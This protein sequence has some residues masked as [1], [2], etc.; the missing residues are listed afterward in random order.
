VDDLLAVDVTESLNNVENV[1]DDTVVLED[2]G[3]E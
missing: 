2:D 1:E 3:V